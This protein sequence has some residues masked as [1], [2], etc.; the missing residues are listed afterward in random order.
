[1][2]GLVGGGMRSFS[3]AVDNVDNEDGAPRSAELVGNNRESAP[4]NTMNLQPTKQDV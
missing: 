2:F 1:M 3:R 4:G